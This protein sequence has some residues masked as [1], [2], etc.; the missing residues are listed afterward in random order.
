MVKLQVTNT[1]ETIYMAPVF[2]C[3][4]LIELLCLGDGS[5]ARSH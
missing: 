3:R 5:R 2:R 1:T 4:G